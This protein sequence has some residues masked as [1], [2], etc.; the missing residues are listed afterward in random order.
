MGNLR[1]QA[2]RFK[3]R[4]RGA[5]LPSDMLKVRGLSDAP[6]ERD[7]DTRGTGLLSRGSSGPGHSLEVTCLRQ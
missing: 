7:E 4:R 2:D 3:G 1:G 5:L 6:V